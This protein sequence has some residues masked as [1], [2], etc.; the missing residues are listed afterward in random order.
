MCSQVLALDKFNPQVAARL[1]GSF[2][3]WRRYDATRQALMKAQLER[4][5]AGASSKDTKEIAQRSLA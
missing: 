3:T 2:N 4:V 5:L 1:C